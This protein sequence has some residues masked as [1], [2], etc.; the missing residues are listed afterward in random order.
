MGIRIFL[1]SPGDT[2]VEPRWGT[3]ELDGGRVFVPCLVAASPVHFFEALTPI[4]V[5]GSPSAT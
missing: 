3:T 1:S 5:G 4:G 2:D